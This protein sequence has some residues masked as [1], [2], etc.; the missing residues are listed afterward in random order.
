MASESQKVKGAGRPIQYDREAAIDSAALLFYEKGFKDT[1]VQDV[2][3]ATGMQTGS[4]YAA[5]G[6]KLSLFLECLDKDLGGLRARVDT[7]LHGECD[8]LE[9]LV[10]FAVPTDTAH[11]RPCF[12]SRALVDFPDRESEVWQRIAEAWRHR[13]EAMRGTVVRGQQSGQ[14]RNDLDAQTIARQLVVKM[15]GGKFLMHYLCGP[16]GAASLLSRDIIVDYLRPR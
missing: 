16:D 6:S 4:V 12:S 5:F 10:A 7:H 2:V 13:D 8:P 11:C 3:A 14:I 1:S 15:I 9:G